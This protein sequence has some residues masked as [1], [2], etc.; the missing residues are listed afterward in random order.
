MGRVKISEPYRSFLLAM[1]LL[2]LNSR[3]EEYKGKIEDEYFIKVKNTYLLTIFPVHQSTPLK[4]SLQK[5]SDLKIVEYRE[6]VSD[7]DVK[8]LVNS[9]DDIVSK[10]SHT[11]LNEF[12]NLNE[13]LEITLDQLYQKNFGIIMDIIKAFFDSRYSAKFI[14][15]ER[16]IIIQY[17]NREEKIEKPEVPIGVDLLNRMEKYVSA[18]V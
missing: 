1:E 8:I 3:K 16:K 10:Y 13:S 11:E 5:L 2:S 18:K 15:E 4:K 9:L 7:F 6:N 14:P 12:S 17:T